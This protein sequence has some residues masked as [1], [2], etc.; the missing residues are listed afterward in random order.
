MSKQIQAQA[1]IGSLSLRGLGLFTDMLA[2]LSADNVT[3]MAMI[4]MEQLGSLFHVNG[5]FA[6]RVPELLT[7]ASS[8]PIGRLTL[9]VGWRRGDSVSLFAESAGGQ[10]ISLLSL[11]ITNIY[12][13]E[14]VG[15]ILSRLSSRLLPKS[16]P[17]A[18]V[19][20]L[21]DV[22]A[23]VASKLNVF[24]F[25]NIL[26]EQTMRVHSAYEKLET[27]IPEGL[28]ELPSVE[29]IVEFLECLSHLRE[30]DTVIRISGSSGVL[31]LLSIVIFMFPLDAI[32]TAESYVIHE[33]EAGGRVVIEICDSAPVQVQ[34]EKKL[35][36]STTLTLPLKV[37]EDGRKIKGAC[38]FAWEGWIARKLQIDM[39]GSGKR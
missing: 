20:H 13:E 29:S 33:G 21:A 14:A 17:R 7:R 8:R 10:A 1:D 18:G 30:D 32:I 15:Q 3:P 5:R 37:C 24:G 16:S 23:L 4:Q 39:R 25:G 38:S 19:V 36:Q 22:A 9:A 11:C 28:L 31:Y 27:T 2:V 26:A 35:S 12:N 6:N 34:V